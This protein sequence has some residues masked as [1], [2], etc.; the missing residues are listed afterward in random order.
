MKYDIIFILIEIILKVILALC[1]VAL[2]YK[3]IILKGRVNKNT[4]VLLTQ[5]R[6]N[7]Y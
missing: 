4:V 1:I 3:N 6:K 5:R 2:V 7:R